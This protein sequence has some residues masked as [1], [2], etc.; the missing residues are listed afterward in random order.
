MASFSPKIGDFIA[1]V[2]LVG[3]SFL[4][5]VFM[6]NAEAGEGDKRFRVVVRDSVVFEGTLAEDT[7]FSVVGAVGAVRIEVEQG[8]V[9]VIE[10]SC[11]KKICV[12]MGFTDDPRKPVLC[13]PNR[14]VVEVMPSGKEGVDAVLE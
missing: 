7:V 14:L 13:V 12:A 1:I 2:V 9:G 8:R 5:S 6:R 3:M 10:S 11:P 4:P